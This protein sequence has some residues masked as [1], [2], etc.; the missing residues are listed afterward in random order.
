MV[1]E[2][3]DDESIEDIHVPESESLHDFENPHLSL[4]ALIGIANYHTMHVTRL[5]YNKLL[6]IILESDSTHNF[7]N[8]EVAKSFGCKFKVISPLTVT[9]G[10]GNQLEI[11]F[12]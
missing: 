2:V 6:H 3:D 11:T 10:G 12:I 8:L 1:F 9:G 7:L 5:H 4:Q